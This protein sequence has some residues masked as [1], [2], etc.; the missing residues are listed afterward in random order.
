MTTA[1]TPWRYGPK[2]YV[3]D[4][5][6]QVIRYEGDTHLLNTAYDVKCD[7]CKT[8]VR[9]S[10]SLPESVAGTICGHCRN[11]IQSIEAGE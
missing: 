3:L 5:N 1:P 10:D 4:A 9:Q 2:H 7:E 11:L 6:G 8:T